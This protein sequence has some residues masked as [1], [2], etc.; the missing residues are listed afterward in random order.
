M[1][2]SWPEVGYGVMESKVDSGN[3]MKHPY[4]RARTTFTY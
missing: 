3:A 1:Q 4:K 2:L